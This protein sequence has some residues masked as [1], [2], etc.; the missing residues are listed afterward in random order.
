MPIITVSLLTGRDAATKGQLIAELT[1]AYGR[2]CGGEDKLY[3]VIDEVER[4]NWGV[5]G[6]QLSSPAATAPR[7]IHGPDETGHR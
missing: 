4:E 6:R 2:V 7:P 5:G 3:V 1:A